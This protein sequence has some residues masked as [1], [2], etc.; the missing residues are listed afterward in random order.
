[1]THLKSKLG[2]I[3]VHF[4]TIYVYFSMK[5]VVVKSLL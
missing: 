5:Q 2:Q 1:M 4:E 3:Y